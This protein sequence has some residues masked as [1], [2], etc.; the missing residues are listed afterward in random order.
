LKGG[1]E[2]K[3]KREFP[4]KKTIAVILKISMNEAE[5]ERK[6]GRTPKPRPPT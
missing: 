3:G 4:D 2:E 6:K 5:K 1:R